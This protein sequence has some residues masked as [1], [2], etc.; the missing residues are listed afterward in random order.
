VTAI[1]LEGESGLTTMLA[2]LLHQN[3]L[4]DP[5]RSRL[6]RDATATLEATDAGVA[7][8]L[9]LDR[10]RLVVADGAA[11]RAHLRVRGP[12]ERLL[13]LAAAPLGG[14]RGPGPRPPPPPPPPLRIGFPDPFRAGGRAVVRDVVRGAV[15][16]E[17]LFAHPFRAARVMRLLSASP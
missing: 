17:G 16:I 2:D 9:R 1:V 7:T 14:G 13:A 12:A 5:S 15:R 3:L 11:A 6:L 4:R 10:G 8:T